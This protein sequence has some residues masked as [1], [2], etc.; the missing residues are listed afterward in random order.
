M[1]R[2]ILIIALALLV[3]AISNPAF[4]D[5]KKKAKKAGKECLDGQKDVL[6][7]PIDSVSYAAG[8]LIGGQ[9]KQQ[10]LPNMN[11]S[12]EAWGDTI[13]TEKF[14]EG[15]RAAL[16]AVN[17]L[18]PQADAEK[19][20]QN[21]EQAVRAESER[22]YRQ[23]NEQWLKDNK[24][25]EGVQTTAS[26]LQYKVITMGT[27]ERPT[28]DDNV[29]VKYEGRFI[30]GKVFDSSYERTPQTNV[31]RANQVIKGWTEGLQLMPVG[32]KFE[33]YIPQELGYG[34]RP[35]GPIKPYSTLVFT[36][37]LVGIKK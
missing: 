14:M 20:F 19:Y 17:Q 30:D 21:Q 18:M 32:S 10:V 35:T 24:G 1:T 28:A 8:M 9:I 25:K 15:I 23:K 36:V 5:G 7:S 4:A 11:A 31:F 37:E 3:G 22:L 29:E 12:F 27:G 6:A 26:G 16:T 2:R 33:F 34:T 13:R